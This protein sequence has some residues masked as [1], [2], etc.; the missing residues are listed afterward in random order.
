MAVFEVSGEE[1]AGLGV[2]I[3]RERLGEMERMGRGIEGK[4]MRE[5]LRFWGGAGRVG[6]FA[7]RF[8]R[9]RRQLGKKGLTGG[10]CQSER[11]RKGLRGFSSRAGLLGRWLRAGLVGLVSF[12]LFYF[13]FLFSVFCFVV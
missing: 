8:Q 7:R 10:S 4:E 1:F 3:K 2:S 5:W 13:F 11:E 9:R 6:G 12:F